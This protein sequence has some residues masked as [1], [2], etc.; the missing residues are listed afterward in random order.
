MRVNSLQQ[1]SAYAFMT[2]SFS[3]VALCLRT[4]QHCAN[5]VQSSINQSISFECKE[6]SINQ[7]I[8]LFWSAKKV[9][10]IN[11]SIS[12]GVQRK[13]NQS[14]S[15]SLSLPP[16]VRKNIHTRGMRHGVESIHNHTHI[17]TNNN[18]LTMYI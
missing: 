12:F 9:H 16:H 10:S 11:Q 7:S 14:I 18:Q 8:N 15:Q 5:R 6:S 1:W 4:S 3:D 17:H 13:F 2:V